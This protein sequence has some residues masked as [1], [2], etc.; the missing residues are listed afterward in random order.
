MKVCLCS[1]VVKYVNFASYICVCVCIRLIR[2]SPPHVLIRM[3]GYSFEVGL[4]DLLFVHSLSPVVCSKKPQNQQQRQQSQKNE[5][6]KEDL[7][8]TQLSNHIHRLE[9][10][11]AALAAVA[12]QSQRQSPEA[13]AVDRLIPPHAIVTPSPSTLSTSYDHS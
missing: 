5:P 9:E 2:P 3:G 12:H 11:V 1:T 4:V 10:T 7:K 6:E 13:G 8:P